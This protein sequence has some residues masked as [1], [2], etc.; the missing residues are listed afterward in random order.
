MSESRKSAV[1]AKCEEATNHR[2]KWIPVGDHASG[3]A[4]EYFQDAQIGYFQI[5]SPYHVVC[6]KFNE[7]THS[8]SIV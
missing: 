2:D 7:E 6:L 8:E 4:L 5:G 3:F 1:L